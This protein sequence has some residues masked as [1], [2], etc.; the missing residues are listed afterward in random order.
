[1]NLFG[2]C[3]WV[4]AEVRSLVRA[5]SGEPPLH[6]IQTAGVIPPLARC[7]LGFPSLSLVCL[8]VSDGMLGP[9]GLLSRLFA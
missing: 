5:M 9:A 2:L 6:A 1:M 8:Q 4:E 3:H 7:N